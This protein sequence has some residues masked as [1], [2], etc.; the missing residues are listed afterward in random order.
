MSS[1]LEGLGPVQLVAERITALYPDEVSLRRV[2]AV[3]KVD[4]VRVPF[5]G[6]AANMGFYAAVEAARQGRL[7]DLVGAMLEEYPVDPWLVGVYG[8]LLRKKGT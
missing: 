3:G 4:A 1:F 2:L 5:D 6:R 7:A 8:L